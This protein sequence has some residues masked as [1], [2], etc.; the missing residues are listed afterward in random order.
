MSLNESELPEN[1]LSKL[2]IGCAIEVQ[3]VL[4]GP[5]LLEGT[6]EEAFAWELNQSGLS[7]ERQVNVPIRYKEVELATP[8][9]ADLI[10]ENLVVV[11]CKAVERVLPIHRTQ[12]LTY[13][14]L[15]DLRLGLLI[16]FGAPT[17]KDGLTRVA[18]KL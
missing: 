9:R 6:Y 13:L 7:F 18:N 14:R 11:E 3:R 10:V 15:L 1:E 12:L 4:G 16:N 8:L 5:G 2:I 17:I